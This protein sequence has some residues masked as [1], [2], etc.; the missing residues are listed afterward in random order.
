MKPDRPRC[1]YIIIQRHSAQNS[2]FCKAGAVG[3]VRSESPAEHPA[4]RSLERISPLN[5]GEHGS[6]LAAMRT[7]SSLMKKLLSVHLFDTAS[8]DSDEGK[9]PRRWLPF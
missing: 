1:A 5:L 4:R 6:S 7:F 2:P 8:L 9:Q 3:S